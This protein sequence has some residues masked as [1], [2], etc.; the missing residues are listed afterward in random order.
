MLYT[1]IIASLYNCCVCRIVENHP[2]I[3]WN[4]WR[5]FVFSDAMCSDFAPLM[6]FSSETIHVWTSLDRW[7]RNTLLIQ[8][9]KY[10]S[11]YLIFNQLPGNSR[12]LMGYWF[13][14]EYWIQYCKDRYHIRNIK[15]KFIFH[16]ALVDKLFGKLQFKCNFPNIHT[17]HINL[18]KYKSRKFNY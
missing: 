18:N 3:V 8:F 1:I 16:F 13:I 7:C 2:K 11:R 9:I 15:P 5:I 12:I 6:R 17:L 4:C 10:S 14:I